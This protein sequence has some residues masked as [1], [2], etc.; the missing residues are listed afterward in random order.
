[1]RLKIKL[2]VITILVL[3]IVT[4]A[5]FTRKNVN[6][7]YVSLGDSLAAGLTP[8]HTIDKSYSDFIAEKLEA[9]GLIG[10]FNK[11]GVT[12]YT[13]KDVLTAIDPANQENS[14]RVMALSK[15]E[16]VTLDVGANDLLNIIPQ[17]TANPIQASTII[18]KVSENIT[19]IIST[20]KNINPKAKIYIMGYYNAFP[21]YPEE[22][23][24]L[25]IPLVKRFNLAIK[26]AVEATGGT[27]IDTYQTMDK[28]LLKYLPENDIHPD[29]LGYQVIADEFWSVIKD[30]LKKTW[31]SLSL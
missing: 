8:K 24:A 4:W 20:L 22:R 11:F 15:A 28:D 14:Q 6:I 23:Q 3:L 25:L 18:Q 12:G 10:D 29:L 17:L 30:D 7:D 21:Y 13:T 2:L 31:L 27:Y 26:Q 5:A 9:K 16:I 1:M 19:K